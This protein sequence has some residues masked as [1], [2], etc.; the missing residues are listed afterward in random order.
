MDG[1]SIGSKRNGMLLVAPNIGNEVTIAAGAIV[2]GQVMVGHGSIVGA[3][4]I[5][6]EDVPSKAVVV[7]DS[8]KVIQW[9]IVPRVMS[10]Y[11]ITE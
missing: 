11:P 3:G 1:D 8:C 2:I 6:V 9:D 7:N 4:A 10:P 5:V